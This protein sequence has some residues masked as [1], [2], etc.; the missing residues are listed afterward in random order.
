MDKYN[1][2]YMNVVGIDHFL[3]EEE[4]KELFQDFD[5]IMNSPETK[6]APFITFE[7]DKQ[8]KFAPVCF[9]AK[10]NYKK[11]GTLEADMVD[12]ALE[13]IDNHGRFS[14]VITD[15]GEKTI[16]VGV[17]DPE[18]TIHQMALS[19][20]RNERITTS[21][22]DGIAR[23]PYLNRENEFEER[24]D[25]LLD[26]L[27][28]YRK[29]NMPADDK[30]CEM[31]EEWIKVYESLHRRTLC[32]EDHGVIKRMR[33]LIEPLDNVEH[34]N[35]Y[36][37]EEGGLSWEISIIYDEAYTLHRH[38]VQNNGTLEIMNYQLN[39]LRE[40]AH[41]PDGFIDEYEKVYLYKAD[42]NK[43]QQE[44]DRIEEWLRTA[45]P[46]NVYARYADDKQKLASNLFYLRLS[47]AELYK[48]YEHI[49]VL[50]E[51]EKRLNNNADNQQAADAPVDTAY[52]NEP[53]VRF[54][55][56]RNYEERKEK[57]NAYFHILM[58]LY[59]NEA[60]ASGIT[61]TW[62]SDQFVHHLI[63]K[64]KNEEHQILRDSVWVKIENTRKGSICF[65]GT[66]LPRLFEVIGLW[67]ARKYIIKTASE[68]SEIIAK[69]IKQQERKDTI[70]VQIQKTIDKVKAYDNPT[71]RGKK[72][73]ITDLPLIVQL[74]LKE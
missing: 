23:L 29:N 50:E 46:Y 72:T 69:K 51:L 38:T 49:L 12:E 73:Q 18:G 17:D 32:R 10:Y 42:Q 11:I 71:P 56:V 30:L 21:A 33:M 2:M 68:L 44:H 43:L 74:F 15:W 8:N 16:I 60:F 53:E 52:S 25:T 37:K 28:Y 3:N 31:L 58:N 54:M 36:N 45:L 65:D 48:V 14:G 13:L 70:R 24:T 61:T 26:V 35:F 39:H 6:I 57:A 4:K 22:L 63:S 19:D 59:K 62:I 66:P 1:W 9:V 67:C 41:Q 34:D 47:R 40:I 64:V 20:T 5:R 27:D 55:P 7:W